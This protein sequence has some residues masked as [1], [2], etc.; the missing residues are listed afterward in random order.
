[1]KNQVKSINNFDE[2]CNSI[3]KQT[4]ELR[5]SYLSITHFTFWNRLNN[6]NII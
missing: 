6:Y 5:Y 4:I 3:D 1:M 2:Y